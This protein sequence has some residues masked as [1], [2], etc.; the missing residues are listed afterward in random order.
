MPLS[1]GKCWTE[2]TL[3]C[4]YHGWTYRLSDGELIAALT[5]GPESAVV[6]KKGK[7]VRSYPVE[8]RN[9]VVYVYMGDGNPPALEE[10]VPEELL[11]PEYVFEAVT[12]VWNR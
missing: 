12:S 10:D 7:G 9:G 6:G 8:E 5:D 11:K 1:D 3:T 4:P 2:G